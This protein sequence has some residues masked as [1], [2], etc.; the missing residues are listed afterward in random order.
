L[1]SLA[2]SFGKNSAAGAAREATGYRFRYI[3]A[4]VAMVYVSVAVWLDIHNYVFQKRFIIIFIL[5]YQRILSLPFLSPASFRPFM[6]L[7]FTDGRMSV[8]GKI[9][10]ANACRTI[11]LRIIM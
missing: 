8:T 7:D 4:F 9:R 3:I 1:G 2:S 11:L 10:R 6:Y 5:P